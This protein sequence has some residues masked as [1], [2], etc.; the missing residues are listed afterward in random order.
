MSLDIN[1]REVV[2]VI[3][4][5]DNDYSDQECFFGYYHHIEEEGKAGEAWTCRVVINKV[6]STWEVGESHSFRGQVITIAETSVRK[7]LI[8]PV[9]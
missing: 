1:T 5:R 2:A 3:T 6:S 9:S 4:S 8:I 7:T